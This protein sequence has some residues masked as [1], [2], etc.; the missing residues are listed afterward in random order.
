MEVELRPWTRDDLDWGF[1]VH[2]QALGP[3]VAATWGWDD[4]EQRVAWE[5]RAAIGRQAVL[6]DGQ[7]AGFFNAAERDDGFWISNIELLPEFQCRGIGTRLLQGVLDRA[8]DAGKPVGLRV[9]RVNPARKLYERLGFAVVSEDDTHY[10]MGRPVPG[11]SP[12]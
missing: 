10:Y 2:R 6:V 12:E 4:A 3:Y 8:D 5:Q 11:A 1:E 7:R 9:L